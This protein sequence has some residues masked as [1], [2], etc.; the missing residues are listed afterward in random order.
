MQ[1]SLQMLIDMIS[2]KDN[3]ILFML[4]FFSENIC[5]NSYLILFINI[6]MASV[7][8]ISLCGIQE[9]IFYIAT[10]FLSKMHF[11]ISSVIYKK[12]DLNVF[13]LLHMLSIYLLLASFAYFHLL[14]GNFS[15][16]YH[17]PL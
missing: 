12:V 8:G 1:S 4:I 13:H 6:E 3:F 17:I 14:T 15:L 16:K 7:V 2:T 9:H 10:N 11:K 5:I